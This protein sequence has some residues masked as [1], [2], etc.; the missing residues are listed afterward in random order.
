MCSKVKL[1]ENKRKINKFLTKI[2]LTKFPT[3][4]PLCIM[5]SMEVVHLALKNDVPLLAESFANGYIPSFAFFY[6]SLEHENGHMEEVTEEIC[7]TWDDVWKKKMKSLRNSWCKTIFNSSRKMFHIWD[8]NHQYMAW[9]KSKC[10]EFD[11]ED[12]HILVRTIILDSR[13]NN[14]VLIIFF[15]MT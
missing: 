8:D 5:I 2:C 14:H 11:H 1:L 7:G 10:D 13:K 3:P 4:S 6:V 12:Y 9:Y 15:T